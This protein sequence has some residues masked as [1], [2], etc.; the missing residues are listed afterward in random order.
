MASKKQAKKRSKKATAKKP[1]AKTPLKKVPVKKPLKKTPKIKS[2]TEEEL[3]EWSEIKRENSNPISR[4]REALFNKAKNLSSPKGKKFKDITIKIHYSKGVVDMKR[5]WLDWEAV[6]AG[7]RLN[8]RVYASNTLVYYEHNDT[9]QAYPLSS[10]RI[11]PKRAELEENFEKIKN[12]YLVKMIGDLKLI[13]LVV[14]VIF[15]SKYVKRR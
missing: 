2:F 9:I 3:E 6:I 7:L 4:T 5:A 15:K 11:Y 12:D 14:H 8:P 13:S 1:I 10:A